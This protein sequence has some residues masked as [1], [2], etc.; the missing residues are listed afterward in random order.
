MRHEQ[1][2]KSMKAN[3]T[4]LVVIKELRSYEITT[5]KKS[6]CY[7]C[8]IILETLKNLPKSL[9]YQLCYNLT[10]E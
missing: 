7:N 10:M 2:F 9:K 4:E 5:D 3:C 6:Q 1:K 8:H